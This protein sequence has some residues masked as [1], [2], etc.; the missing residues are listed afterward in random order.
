MSKRE[1]KYLLTID[2]TEQLVKKV[3]LTIFVTRM[4]SLKSSTE[5]CS[6]PS[7]IN[8]TRLLV[9]VGFGFGQSFNWCCVEP[10]RKQEPFSRFGAGQLPERCPKPEQL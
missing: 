2:C 7:L 10:H 5:F 3:T 6:E 9:G 8:A 4:A 1:T